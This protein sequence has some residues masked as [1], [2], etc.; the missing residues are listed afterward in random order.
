MHDRSK[1]ARTYARTTRNCLTISIEPRRVEWFGYFWV[2][3]LS[4]ARSGLGLG[5]IV[6]PYFTMLSHG[7]LVP[8]FPCYHEE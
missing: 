3:L 4:P 6:I 2:E 5:S 1:L 8:C 7:M